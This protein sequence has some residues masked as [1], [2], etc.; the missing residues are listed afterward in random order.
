MVKNSAI[1]SA[2]VGVTLAIETEDRMKFIQFLAKYGKSY[3][4]IDHHE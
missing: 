2:L 1:L 4:S 3:A